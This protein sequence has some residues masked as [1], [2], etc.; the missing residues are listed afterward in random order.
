MVIDFQN[1]F[2]SKQGALPMAEDAD[3]DAVVERT[4]NLVRAFRSM[5]DIIIW[6]QSQF[7]QKRPFAERQDIITQDPV[8]SPGARGPS[9]QSTPLHDADAFLSQNPPRC[10]VRGTFGWE[11]APALK[12]LV[13][14]KRDIFVMKSS[15]SAFSGTRLLERLRPKFITTLFLCGS[16]TNV[17]VHATAMEAASY[18][19]A[20]TLVRDCC[21]WTSEVR[22][23]LAETNLMD[24]TGCDAISSS[25]LMESVGN[26]PATRN[27]PSEPI[28]APFVSLK[29]AEWADKDSGDKD[30]GAKRPAPALPRP[31][32]TATTEAT[33]RHQPKEPLDPVDDVIERLSVSTIGDDAESPAPAVLTFDDAPS[34]KPTL[35]DS[36]A[37]STTAMEE[38]ARTTSAAQGSTA[39][40]E[41]RL[42]STLD[43]SPEPCPKTRDT[44]SPMSDSTITTTTRSRSEASVNPHQGKMA[45]DAPAVSGHICEGDTTV[46][47]NVLPPA[48]E[49][50]VFE[51]LREEVDWQRMSHQ[52]GEVPRLVA[53][54][55]E[56]APDG[57]MPVYRHPSDQSPP[58]VAFSPTVLKLKEE[59]EKHLGHGLNHVLIQLYRNSKDYISEH[60][61][62]T[63]DV[64]RGTFIAN[65]SLGAERTMVF[66]TKRADRDFTMTHQSPPPSS[67]T[68]RQVQKAKLPH[69]SLCRMGLQTNM[70]WLHA[71]KQDKRRDAEKTPAELAFGGGRISLT[72]RRIGTFLDA[73]QTLIWGQGATGK[74][75][76]EAKPVINGNEELTGEVVRAFGTENHASE[77]DWEAHYG[78][79]FDVLHMSHRR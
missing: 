46:I 33:E 76:D 42:K 24:T 26:N 23:K 12:V 3:A 49:D 45:A 56:V 16:L 32:T 34:R 38:H 28:N 18:A 2:V 58:L 13:D 63:L 53:V 10:V 40:S 64:A 65:L 21:G 61:D 70:R 17:G 8:A 67:P 52:G 47:Y 54:Q 79:G 75:R 15:Y 30:G 36:T 7:D 43:P 68:Q 59:V 5:G 19:L 27:A 66:R 73:H 44:S 69:N 6:V 41:P 71:I 74:T 48:L 77:F 78:R 14:F 31:G 25:K 9:P 72:F 29:R 51:K 50:G 1:D 4:A 57:S 55:G 62:K 22:S 60:S 35:G 11:M 39:A 20:V 37:T